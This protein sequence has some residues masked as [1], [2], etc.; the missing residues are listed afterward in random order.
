MAVRTPLS[1]STT[2]TT[3]RSSPAEMFVSWLTSFDKPDEIR[4]GGT[5][6]V[7]VPLSLFLGGLSTSSEMLPADAAAEVGMSAGTK[8]G[9]AATELLLA[10]NDPAGPRCRSY[11]SA[12]YYLRDL[13]RWDPVAESIP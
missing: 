6:G 13:D 10:V 7:S 9:D 11:R 1:A 3:T 2:A 8:L 12:V 4:I 5:G